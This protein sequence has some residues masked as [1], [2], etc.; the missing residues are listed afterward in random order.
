[1]V[2]WAAK[3]ELDKKEELSEPHAKEQQYTAQEVHDLAKNSLDFLA[4]LALP[5]LFRYFFPVVYK[6]IWTWLLSYIHRS[7]DFSQLALGLPRGFA[8][9][10]FVKIFVLYVLLFT[11]RKFILVCAETQTKANNIISDICDMLEEE[12]I[13]KVFGNWKIGLEKDTQDLKKFG[14]RGRNITLAAGTVATVRGLN[15]KNERPDLMIF[16]DIQSRVQAESQVISEQIETDM[17]GTAMKAKSPHGCLFIFVGNMYP[18]KWSILRK[19]K[20]SVNWVKF[21]AGGILADG[22]SLWEDL[23]PLQQLLTEYQNDLDMGHPEIFFAE[24]LNDEN[25]TV[26]NLVDISK[27]PAFPFDDDE[28]HSGNF[29]LIDPSNDKTNSDA[30]SLGYFEVRSTDNAVVPC[31]MEVLE[32]RF[33]PGDTILAAIEMALRH[34]CRLV[35]IESNAYQYSLNYWF[36]FICLQRGISGIECAPI[37]SG[38]RSKNSRILDMFKSLFAKELYY[39]PSTSAP[40]NSQISQ[41]NPLKTANIDGILDLLT[42][43]PRVIA[44][45]GEQLISGSIIEM[46][47]HNSIPVLPAGANSP[48]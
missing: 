34:N 44:E 10:T 26:N 21:I 22:T 31:M 3:L 42:Y 16:E 19:L 33:S 4:A 46:Q 37:Y 5:A 6:S 30:V 15:I 9:T 28:L 47:E 1:M 8:K 12:N 7:R 48:I 38:S 29:I 35:V 32:G 13:K 45:F 41:F 17:V 11:S 2:D 25:A 36:E 24:V 20:K 43:A 27:L 23:Q 18:T 40:V 39:H 14:F